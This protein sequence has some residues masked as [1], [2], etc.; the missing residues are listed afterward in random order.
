MVQEKGLPA[1]LSKILSGYSW[2]KIT[3]GQSE[4]TVYRM[5]GLRRNFYL[6]MQPLDAVE[7]LS[8]EKER[9]EIRFLEDF[10]RNRTLD[11]LLFLNCTSS[12]FRGHTVP[13]LL[14]N[15]STSL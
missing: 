9:L 8:S 4:S 13:Y 3:I 7:H 10:G 12:D 15:T 5:S 11:A 2:N 6:K 1:E 14:Q